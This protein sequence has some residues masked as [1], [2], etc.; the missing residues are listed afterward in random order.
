ML[1]SYLAGLMGWFVMSTTR[2]NVPGQSLP[3]VRPDGGLLLL[4]ER[5]LLEERPPDPAARVQEGVAAGPRP[6]GVRVVGR[7]HH[8]L[9]PDDLRGPPQVALA[10]RAAARHPEILAEVVGEG[11]LQVRVE[12]HDPRVVEVEQDDLSPVP[13]D[14]LQPGVAVEDAREDHPEV[15]HAQIVVLFDEIV[16]FVER[17]TANARTTALALHEKVFGYHRYENSAERAGDPRPMKMLL[18]CDTERDA[19]YALAASVEHPTL[20]PRQ[21]GL[22]SWQTRRMPIGASSP[23]AVAGAI[24]EEAI[25]RLSSGQPA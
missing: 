4:G 23:S 16:F 25:E 7:V 14:H 24:R 8:P 1:Q 12:R 11:P 20:T 17:Q 13:G 15:L 10:H 19:R 9:G 6:E 2:R 21:A 18:A 5:R 3:V 22:K